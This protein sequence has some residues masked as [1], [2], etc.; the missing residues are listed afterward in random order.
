MG[1]VPRLYVKDD[2]AIGQSITVDDAQ[3]KYLTR[4]MRLADGASVRV[5][6]GRDGEWVATL[7]TQGKTVLLE[8]RSQLRAQT[9]GPDLTLLFAPLKKARTDFVVEKSTELGVR[10]IRPVLTEY[11]Q[12][13]KVRLDR[14]QSLVI[15]AAEQ[16]ERLDIPMVSDAA[17]L[18]TALADWPGD[19]PL[20]YCDEGSE[21]R[22]IA[23]A[24][25]AAGEGAAGVLIGP[26]G[27]FSPRERGFL[28]ALD[29]VIPVT[30]GPRILRAETAVVS[31]LS[32]WQSQVG[33]WRDAPYVPE[34]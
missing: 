33:D 1:H 27:G 18:T 21:A 15:E 2:L 13:Q 8:P 4:V 29:F 34:T 14:F 23:E 30:L 9:P 12:T 25:A 7:R 3:G 11:T 5:F 24:I 31:A 26:E 17:P 22:P 16:T 19:R 10:E 32:V 28:R 20:Y 6:N